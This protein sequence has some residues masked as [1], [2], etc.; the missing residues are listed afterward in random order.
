MYTYLQTEPSQASS[1]FT[2][3]RIDVEQ[4]VTEALAAGQGN[5]WERNSTIPC[6]YLIY[7]C[8]CNI[9]PTYT[10]A[11]IRIYIYIYMMYVIMMYGHLGIIA[12][13]VMHA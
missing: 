7:A 1:A 10:C 13:R 2:D 11:C 5:R 3:S 9:L 4:E 8:M 12:V 6:V